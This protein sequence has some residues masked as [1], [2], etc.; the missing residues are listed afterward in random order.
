MAKIGD[1][2]YFLGLQNRGI[3]D[4]SRSLAT[5]KCFEK[6]LSADSVYC[7]DSQ[8]EALISNFPPSADQKCLF[9]SLNRPLKEVSVH[10][11]E[12]F[13]CVIEILTVSNSNWR[14]QIHIDVLKVVFDF[15]K[16]FRTLFEIIRLNL[17]AFTKLLKYLSYIFLNHWDE[18]NWFH[19]NFLNIVRNCILR[20]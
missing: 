4:K 9:F 5:L 6:L 7:H 13:L 18:L 12:R 16:I 17:F 10:F 11:F 8:S 19:E 15:M 20:H 14:S 1:F 2:D 3:G